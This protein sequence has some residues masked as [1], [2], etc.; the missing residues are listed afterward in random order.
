MNTEKRFALFE[1]MPVPRAVLTLAVPTILS[2]L[3]DAREKHAM[4]YT[5]CRGLSQ[6]TNGLFFLHLKKLTL[7]RIEV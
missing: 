2:S 6:V 4:R 7:N 3:A 5:P 1:Q